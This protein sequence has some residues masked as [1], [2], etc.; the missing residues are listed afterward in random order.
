[1][2]VVAKNCFYYMSLNDIEPDQRKMDMTYSDIEGIKYVSVC[3]FC[4][5]DRIE[6]I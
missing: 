2:H 6:W 3:L 1:M 4:A 5:K